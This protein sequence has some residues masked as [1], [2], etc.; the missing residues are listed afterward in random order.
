MISVL[1]VFNDLVPTYADLVTDQQSWSISQSLVIAKQISAMAQNI[2][3]WL[4][5]GIQFRLLEH[6]FY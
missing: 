1:D 4:Y 6:C 5:H 3:S 2:C